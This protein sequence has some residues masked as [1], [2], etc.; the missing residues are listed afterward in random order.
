MLEG[1]VAIV[2]GAASG[3]GRAAALVYAREGARVVV[4]DIQEEGG[5]ETA[6]RVQRAGGK[7]VFVQADVSQPE[8]AQRLVER[9]VS[10]FGQLDIAFNNAGIGGELAA[11]A[12]YPL[13]AWQRVI[14]V[15]LSGV[16]YAMKY[17]LGHM[18][19]HGGGVIINMSS[20]LGQVGFAGAPAYSAAKH[21]VVGLTQAAA[22][23]HSASG[24][25]INA[26]GPGFIHTPMIAGLEAD[27]A[28]LKQLQALH[29]IGRLGTADEVAELVA[30]L[31]SERASFITGA[32]YPV[33]GGFLAR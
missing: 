13:D 33:D 11:T 28:T 18:L 7:A 32:Y 25:R 3:I 30:W 17:Q 22:L 24:V 26:I 8:D 27:D 16:F 12:D 19:A 9:A 14:A 4:S 1:K 6:G 23:D 2:T 20:I 29:P 5:E 15:N 31:S 10:A 21:G